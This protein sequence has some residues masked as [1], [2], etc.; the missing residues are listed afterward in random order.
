MER[1]P[2]SFSITHYI[3]VEYG[4]SVNLEPDPA[5][6]PFEFRGR[7][8]RSGKASDGNVKGD[9]ARVTHEINCS[10]TD[11]DFTI[12]QTITDQNGNSY[13]LLIPD[14]GQKASKLWVAYI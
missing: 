5:N 1:Y 10:V 3:Q 12:G 6:P 11:Y 9:M 8:T 2:D 7:I 4:S 14:V 13:E